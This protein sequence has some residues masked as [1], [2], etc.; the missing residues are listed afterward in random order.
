[1][2]ICACI[3]IGRQVL[4][5]ASSK[6]E[7]SP[8]SPSFIPNNMSGSCCSW[9]LE[10]QRSLIQFEGRSFSRSPVIPALY[11]SPSWLPKKVVPEKT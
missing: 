5:S 3:R 10:D 9:R 8:H 1:L 6:E 4:F 11:S 7:D 2:N